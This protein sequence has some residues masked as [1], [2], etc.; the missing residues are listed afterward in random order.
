MDKIEFLILRNLLHNEDF[1]RKVIPFVKPEYFEDA[2]QRIVYEEIQ[3]FVTQY[4][5]R[6]TNCGS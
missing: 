1:W 4:N 6:P 5:A 3:S 2:N